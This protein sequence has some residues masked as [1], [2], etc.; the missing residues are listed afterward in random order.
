MLT[1]KHYASAAVYELTFLHFADRRL[2]TATQCGPRRCLD[3]GMWVGSWHRPPQLPVQ[4]RL[5][6]VLI[7][8]ILLLLPLLLDVL[9]GATSPARDGPVA[10]LA[11]GAIDAVP[12]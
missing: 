9:P 1:I 6:L 11:R 10:A 3:L 12:L 7:A 5:L 8:L 2:T 4:V